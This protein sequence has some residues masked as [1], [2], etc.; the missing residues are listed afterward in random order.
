[1][2]NEY[3]KKKFECYIISVNSYVIIKIGNVNLTLTSYSWVVS[4]QFLTSNRRI[5]TPLPKT[6][7][8]IGKMKRVFI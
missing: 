4:V 7:C 1:M 6:I 5:I 2:M 8:W 3:M